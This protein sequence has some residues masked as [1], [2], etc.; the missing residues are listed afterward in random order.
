MRTNVPLICL[1]LLAGLLGLAAGSRAD[2]GARP[3]S[4]RMGTLIGLVTRWPASPVQGPGLPAAAAPAPGVKLVVYGPGRQEAATVLTDQ[5]G[6]Y[7]LQLPPGS[8][9]IELAPDQGRGFTKNLP[10]TVTITQGQETRLNIRLD[11]GMR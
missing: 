11:T 3:P 10:A 8:Y 5:A 1:A 4:A 7:R 9:L 2:A 6:H